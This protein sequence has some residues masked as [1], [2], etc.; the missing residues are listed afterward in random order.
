VN[1]V[2]PRFTPLRAP[3]SRAQ[4]AVLLTGPLLWIGA[5]AVVAAVVGQL[6]QAGVVTLITAVSVVA[7][8]PVLLLG[9]VRCRRAE[10]RAGRPDG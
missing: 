3:P 10:R 1:N 6:E 4:I 7:A 5:L 9:R 2:P 8:I